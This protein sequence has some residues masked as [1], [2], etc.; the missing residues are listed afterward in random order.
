MI[1]IA[2]NIIARNASSDLKVL[3][4]QIKQVADE[5]III[6]DDRTTDD[7]MEV[8]KMLDCSATLY[9]WTE[10]FKGA[11]NAAIELTKSQYVVWTDCD[12]RIEDFTAL[13]D[14]KKSHDDLKTIF[15]FKV[16]N[17]PGTTLFNQVRMF[18]NHPAVRF[19]YRIHET[20]DSGVVAKGFSIK[21]LDFIVQ[22]W[23]YADKSR[24][25]EKFFRNLPLIK[26]E[27][28]SGS[29][30]PSLRFTYAMNLVALNKPIEA[31]EYFKSIITETV[32][33]SPFRDVFIFAILNL[34]K[35]LIKRQ[36]YTLAE[37]YIRVGLQT[38]PDF[39][40]LHLL[41]AKIGQ[42]T[43]DYMNG[44]WSLKVAAKC[45]E[46][47]YSIAT[48]W[49]AIGQQINDLYVKFHQIT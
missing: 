33:T 40:E 21:P 30:C 3:V 38:L 27:I 44:Y 8:A 23:G 18:P 43:R 5:V 37:Y 11:R 9:K 10:G 49:D 48:S 15:T 34:A 46:R 19:V 28:D 41:R 42:E 2:F 12:D 24:L 14:L 22:H 32:R 36:E 25:R 35:L 45:P 26:E 7:T 47:S 6:V 16:Q 39:K 13:K 31:I 20:I 4:P 29:F 17:M 1:S